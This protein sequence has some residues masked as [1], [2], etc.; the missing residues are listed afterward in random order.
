MSNMGNPIQPFFVLNTDYYLKH[1]ANGGII[2][3]FYSFESNQ[4]I[5]SEYGAVPD[6]T[7]DIIFV[8]DEKNPRAMLAGGVLQKKENVFEP[9][10]RYFG[11]RISPG[12]I[13]KSGTIS[14]REL[15]DKLVDF[16][17]IVENHSLVEQICM[18]DSFAEQI[19]LFSEGLPG[20]MNGGDISTKL[21]LCQSIV[22]ILYRNQGN[23]TMSQLEQE[24]CYSRQHLSRVFKECMGMEIKQT[25][26]IIRFQE[27]IYNM[28]HNGGN[29]PMA[30]FSIDSG[31]YD[32]PHFQK[33]FLKYT[34][35]TPAKYRELIENNNYK[36]RIKLI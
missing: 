2:S 11:L 10:T 6:G 14:A 31:Y 20:F 26:M 7:A 18:E 19:K 28:T 34:G 35:L 9:N 36:S 23:C 1:L 29:I 8:C 3:H 25:A 12:M 17:E 4:E 24:L 5:I 22:D 15:G 27:S 33:E 16:G 13:E 30:D 21:K 32:Q